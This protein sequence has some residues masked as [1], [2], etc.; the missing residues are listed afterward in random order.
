MRRLHRAKDAAYR[1][2]WKKRGEVMSI[3][4]NIARKVDRLENVATGAPSTSD[5]SI[6]DTAVDLLVY[7]LKYQTYL[8]DQDASVAT[9]LF[10]Q[11]STGAP[12]SDGP[13]GFE[14]LLAQQNMTDIEQVRGPRV[15]QAV[16]EISNV[17]DELEACFQGTPASAEQRAAIAALLAETAISL[18]GSLI[19]EAPERYRD[20]LL[21]DT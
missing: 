12:Y 11:S 7:T 6:L 4:A 3:M 17:F 14:V 13:S 18:I 5:E 21:T 9:T 20:F 8:A 16:R 1:N 19:R 10:R 15:E 2:S